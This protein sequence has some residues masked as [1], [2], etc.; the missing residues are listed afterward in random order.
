MSIVSWNC[1]GLGRSQD[2]TIPRLMEIRKKYFPEVL[3]LMETMHSR[4]VLVDIQIWLGYERVY[5]VEPV[6]KCGGLAVFWKSTVAVEV[7]SANKN[8]IDLEMQVGDKKFFAT[9]VYGDPMES[10]RRKV[11][12]RM[13][14]LNVNRRQP[15][16]IFGDFNAIRS[17]EEKIGGTLRGKAAFV[18]FNNMLNGCKMEEL[19]SRGD[20]FTWGGTRGKYSV[21]SKLDR[22]FA[23]E[24]WLRTFPVANQVCLDKRGSDHRHVMINLVT[25]SGKMKG[26]FRFDK[27]LLNLPNVQATVIKAWKGKGRGVA[28]RVSERIRR[29]RSALSRWKK[30]F[31]LNARDKIAKLQ[32][33]LEEEQ[34]LRMPRRYKILCLKQKLMK[35]YRE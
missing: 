30:D 24:R 2:L 8:I 26:N 32:E 35:A 9:C 29:C 14:R 3:F 21:Q 33:A 25:S 11:L 12:E 13:Q 20:S 7:L 34:S 27:S 5:T 18:D 4:N 31:Q 10:K 22:W 15:W 23:N 6:G 17:N 28:C 1:Q 19:K 16:C